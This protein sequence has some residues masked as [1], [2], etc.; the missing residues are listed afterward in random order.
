MRRVA[1]NADAMAS[2]NLGNLSKGGGDNGEVLCSKGAPRNSKKLAQRHPL[3]IFGLNPKKKNTPRGA[4]FGRPK[5]L[6]TYSA[7][8][9]PPNSQRPN[10]CHRAT[11]C[12]TANSRS[13]TLRRAA[14][15]APT[16]RVVGARKP[17]IDAWRA[18][19]PPVLST[20]RSSRP[21]ERLPSCQ[22][23]AAHAS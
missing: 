5:L 16:A 8:E 9:T 2:K 1:E 17:H 23:P 13:S 20:T 7:P 11:W 3:P 12:R 4:I 10:R 21:C 19:A 18:H 15:P 22:P 14:L 6:S